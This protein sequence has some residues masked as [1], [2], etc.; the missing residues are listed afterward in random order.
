MTDTEAK[1]TE[2]IR[3]WEKSGLPLERF[4]E[5]KP[6]R[7]STFL[8]RKRQLERRKRREVEQQRRGGA[9]GGRGTSLVSKAKGT[10]QH[11]KPKS[12]PIS[13][14][15]VVRKPAATYDLTGVVVEIGTARIRVG[16]GFDAALL[17]EVVRALQGAA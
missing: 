4:V 11:S 1:W 10:E 13:L 14:L 7:A 17:R 15:E 6:Y 16:A 12:S 8:W 3:E 2:R 5:G 9:G